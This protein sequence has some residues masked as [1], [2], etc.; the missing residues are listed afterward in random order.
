VFRDDVVPMNTGRSYHPQRQVAP[1]TALVFEVRSENEEFLVP[2]GGP[3]VP[4]SAENL[5]TTPLTLVAHA[6]VRN[7][8]DVR[9]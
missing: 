6:T 3:G 7:Y 5:G 1:A 4:L 9:R 2:G 8:L